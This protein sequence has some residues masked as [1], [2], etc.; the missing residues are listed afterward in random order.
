MNAALRHAGVAPLPIAELARILHSRS[1]PWKGLALIWAYFD[2]AGTHQGSEVTTI[3]GLVGTEQAWTAFEADWLAV[4]NEFREYGLAAFHAYECEVREG[5]FERLSREIREAISRKFSRIIAE[6]TDL[7][8]FWSSV[9]NAAWEDVADQAFKERYQKP[10]GLC[11][12]W[13]VQQV[14]RWSVNYADSSP[15]ALIFS[16]Q[17]DFQD[18]MHEVFSHYIGA[19]RYSPLRTLTFGS[20]RD[21]VPL[22]GADLIATE[23]NRYWRAAE[24]NPAALSS[25]RCKRRSNNPSLKRPGNPVA[26]E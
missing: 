26:P 24:L 8:P 11:F 17:L 5:N 6:H 19:K 1:N 9:I 25:R 12:E 16:E 15:V 14:A 7:R 10:F 2:D 21:L 13:C 23:I 4:I 18:R 3:G 20:Y 22:Q